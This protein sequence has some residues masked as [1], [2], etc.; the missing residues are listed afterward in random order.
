MTNLII[1]II[2]PVYNAQNY[3]EKCINSILNQDMENYEVIVIN[4]DSTDSTAEILKKYAKDKKIVL[5]RR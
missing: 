1:S 5:I 2:V 3:I 4:D